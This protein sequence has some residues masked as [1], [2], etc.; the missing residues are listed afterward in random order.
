MSNFY[1][2]NFA[3]QSIATVLLLCI[4][5]ISACSVFETRDPEDPGSTTVPVFIP[6]LH[7]QNVIENLQ[8]AMRTLNVDN[9]LKCL[10][11]ESFTYEPSIAA[12]SNDPDTWQGWGFEE[13][14]TYLNNMRSDAEG[15]GGHELKLENTSSA[16]IGEDAERFEANYTLTI[17][18]NRQTTLPSQA[19]GKI[20]LN[21][22]RDEESG[23]WIIQSWRD[24][25]EGSDFTW[26]DFR[27]NFMF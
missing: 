4:V 27:A 9:Y 17:E 14:K 7:P 5:L 18:H 8:N 26:S 3:M 13:E 19:S 24:S 20:Q 21:L 10:S 22:I 12:Q 6:P 11:N 25:S 23:E 1:H 2:S 15:Q 16:P